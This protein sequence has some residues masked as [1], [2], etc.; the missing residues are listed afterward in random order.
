MAKGVV[1]PHSVSSDLSQP[2]LGNNHLSLLDL[3]CKQSRLHDL[4]C[5]QPRSRTPRQNCLSADGLRFFYD[6]ERSPSKMFCVDVNFSVLSQSWAGSAIIIRAWAGSA[7]IIKA[8]SSVDNATCVQLRSCDCV[9]AQFNLEKNTK[10]SV[11]FELF[12]GV[13]A[14]TNHVVLVFVRLAEH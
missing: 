3:C 9:K 6:S 8:R 5:K 10:A 1:V 2:A 7:V 11:S 4:R 14:A 12:T 13:R